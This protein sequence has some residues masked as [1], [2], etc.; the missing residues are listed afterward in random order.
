M[1]STSATIK[2]FLT[3]VDRAALHVRD[4]GAWVPKIN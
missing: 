3:R 4:D 1:I 2:D